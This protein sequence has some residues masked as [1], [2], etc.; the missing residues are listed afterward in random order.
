MGGIKT[1]IWQRNQI[2]ILDAY[3]VDINGDPA[4]IN[5]P[6]MNEVTWMTVVPWTVAFNLTLGY[7][8]NRKRSE[9]M[10]LT[11]Q[12]DAQPIITDPLITEN[13]EVLSL[14]TSNLSTPEI[15][16]L[17]WDSVSGEAVA[18]GTVVFPRRPIGSRPDFVADRHH[19]GTA[20]LGRTG[21]ATTSLA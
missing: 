3:T 6:A 16:F 21:L 11:L 4:P 2:G 5:I 17:N 18:L 10:F 14:Q 20:G 12:G 15:D 7:E 9:F 19:G 13:T 1:L 8:A